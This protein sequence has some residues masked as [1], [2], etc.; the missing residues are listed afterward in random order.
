VTSSRTPG[1]PTAPD[2]VPDVAPPARGEGEAGKF[3]EGS[4][5]RHVLVMAA[6]GSVGLMAIFVVDLLNLFYISLLGEQELAAA[7]GYAGTVLFFITSVGIGV[8]IA[9]SALVSRAL[10]ARDRPA[11]RRIAASGLGFMAIVMIALSVLAYVV[12][13]PLLTM[14]GAAGRTKELAYRFLVL[15]LP[16]NA[17]LGL[18]M[19]YSGI[20]RAVGDAQR[21]MWVTLSAGIAAAIAD[22]VLIFGFGLGLDGAA[23]A[24]ILSR[25][26][27]TAIGFHGAVVVH[28]LVARPSP[29]DMIRDM[30][31]LGAIAGPAVLTNIATPVANGYVTAEIARFGDPA[32]AAWAVIGRLVPVAFGAVFALSG[33]IG[34][35]LGQNLG[36]KRYDRLKRILTDALVVTLVYVV[37]MWA[38]LA[39]AQDA[40]VTAFAATGDAA[41]LIRF[42]C[43]FVA[44]TFVFMGA[45]FVA[46]AAF[47]TLGAPLYATAFNWGRATL[48]TV[49]FATL[50]GRWF[51]AEGVLAGQGLGAIAFGVGAVAVA[52]MVI[53]RLE[54]K[55]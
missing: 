10:G 5:L 30:A 46:N 11:A 38:L 51:G 20:L 29:V 35:I 6:T 36:A 49:P 39:L 26:L 24:M 16:S 28:D 4:T 7:I 27:L 53:A 42:Y 31:A 23:I 15:T 41:A 3:T 18:G 22:P 19:A 50:G 40:V 45:L 1:D 21:A 14:L 44:G 37:V 33:S 47:N 2:P 32:V 54:R 17:F 13:D 48:G 8:T 34:P 52:Y 12:M 9:V 43:G 55:G 25:L